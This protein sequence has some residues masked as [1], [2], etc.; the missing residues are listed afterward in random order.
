MKNNKKQMIDIDEIKPGDNLFYNADENK[1]LI[2]KEIDLDETVMF[3]LP[4]I[5]L[6]E[7]EDWIDIENNTPVFVLE[8][9]Y[10]DYHPYFGPMG[11][12]KVLANINNKPLVGNIASFYL[13]NISQ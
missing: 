1:D 10:K 7:Y 9:T 4:G 5:Y 6:D 12:V 3:A 11:L 13:F 2:M 8:A